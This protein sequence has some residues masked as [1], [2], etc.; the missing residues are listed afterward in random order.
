MYAEFYYLPGLFHFPYLALSYRTAPHVVLPYLTS[1]NF[2]L[3]YRTVLGLWFMISPKPVPWNRIE[4]NRWISPVYLCK[5]R[6]WLLCK[7][8]Q[9]LDA[10]V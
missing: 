2:T 3:P 9:A 5:V 7:Y 4:S 8:S 1:P 10:G 6:W